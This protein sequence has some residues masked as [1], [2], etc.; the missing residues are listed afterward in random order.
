MLNALGSVLGTVATGLF[1]SAEANKD[2][3][4]Q[5]SMSNTSYQRAMRDMELAGLNPMLAA[6]IGGAA[7]PG[8][9]TAAW[10]DIGSSLTNANQV[11]N[12]EKQIDANINKINAE[13]AAIGQQMQLTK[14]Q[15]V[16]A[17]QEFYRIAAQRELLIQQADSTEQEAIFKEME[18]EFIQKMQQATDSSVSGTTWRAIIQG[19]IRSWIGK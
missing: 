5:E 11:E 6:K 12:Q 3:T 7:V 16:N 2:R 15:I 1:N 10:P 9:A 18:N 14:E 8:G 19:A 4:F 13:I 17:Q